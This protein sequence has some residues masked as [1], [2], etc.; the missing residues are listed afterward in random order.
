MNKNIYRIL[1]I[2]FSMM[3]TSCSTEIVTKSGQDFFVHHNL[4]HL[5]GWVVFPRMMF[6]F[7]S[8]MSGGL[9][10]WIGVLFVPRVMVAFCATYYYWDTNPILCIFSW[11]YAIGGEGFE[12][13][14]LNRK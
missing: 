2:C 4:W 6:W 5:L 10:F 12:K 1:L 7:F 14:K 13:S 3:L 8:V 11:F 9:F